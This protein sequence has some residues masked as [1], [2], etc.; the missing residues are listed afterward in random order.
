M[1]R[2]YLNKILHHPKFSRVPKNSKRILSHESVKT[3]ELNIAGNHHHVMALNEVLLVH[4][5]HRRIP[6]YGRKSKH[7]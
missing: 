2:L 6:S 4:H 5:V 3:D 1:R 7:A